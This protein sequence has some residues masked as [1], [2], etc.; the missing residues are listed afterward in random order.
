MSSLARNPNAQP[1]PVRGDTRV[2]ASWPFSK[3]TMQRRSPQVRENAVE[4]QS[5]MTAISGSAFTRSRNS[6]SHP[7]VNACMI[8]GANTTRSHASLRGTGENRDAINT[9]ITEN[10]EFITRFDR[11]A[12]G[13]GRIQERMG[14]ADELG[15]VVVE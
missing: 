10:A 9:E 11:P 14:S 5:P 13:A 6:C 2:S 8:S 12:R 7:S 4:N 1:A 3:R 15:G